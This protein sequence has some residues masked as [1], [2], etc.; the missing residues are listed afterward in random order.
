M[1][2]LPSGRERER[3]REREGEEMTFWV[4]VVLPALSLSLSLSLSLEG[5]IAA[6]IRSREESYFAAAA[7]VE[8]KGV[9]R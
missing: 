3:E 6:L 4:G 1:A 2:L 9:G 5:F 8:E 7:V